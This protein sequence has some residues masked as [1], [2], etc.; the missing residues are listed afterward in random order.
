MAVEYTTFGSSD[1]V[2]TLTG[3]VWSIAL[4]GVVKGD[5]TDVF[6]GD[7]LEVIRYVGLGVCASNNFV[8]LLNMFHLGVRVVAL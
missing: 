6:Q 4:S 2:T 3:S 7:R 5:Q 1:D 8:Q